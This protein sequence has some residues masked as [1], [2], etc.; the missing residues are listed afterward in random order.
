ML[1]LLV[2]LTQIGLLDSASMIPVSIVT[3]A[4]LLGGPSPVVRST[5]LLL[6]VFTTYLVSGLLVL[7]GL[8]KIFDQISAYTLRVW[9]NPKTEE[10]VF[11]IAIGFVLCALAS[12]IATGRKRRS[13]KSVKSGMTT[14]QAAV[15][16]AVIVVTGLPGA[17]PYFAAIDLILRSDVSLWQQTLALGYYNIVFISPLVAVMA[18]VLLAGDRGK[19]FLDKIM[20]FIDAWGKTIVVALLLTLGI[21]LIADG[22]GWLLGHPLLPV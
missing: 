5:A 6:G 21:V 18:L 7:L 4:M 1:D 13:E 17:L 16:G 22:A 15:S 3:L 20:R 19:V 12:R 9:E 10:L 14:G 8:Q 11:Q 2:V